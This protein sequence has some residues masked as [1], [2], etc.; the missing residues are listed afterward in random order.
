VIDCALVVPAY[1]E[2][3]EI[4]SVVADLAAI[5]PV[6]VV[7][8]ASP[9]DTAER[10]R[11]AG[12]VV[13]SLT[14]NRGYGA[15]ID[16]GFREAVDRG[17]GHVV[18]VDG[19]GQHDPADVR[20]MVEQVTAGAYDL[21]VGIR[22][23][24]TRPVERLCAL[25]ARAAFGVRDPLC[26]LKAYDTRFFAEY[27]GFNRLESVGTELMT[28]ALRHGARWTQWPIAIRTRPNGDS[29]FYRNMRGNLRILRSLR[30]LVL[31]R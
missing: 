31:V 21:V 10:A 24:V 19:D 27:G 23:E 20:R 8:D 14:E 2:A 29:R 12:A 9:D 22:P 4:A 6:I 16:A 18:T 11:A 3:G 1:R 7:D 30:A 5:A 17:F 15:A 13:I 25:Y 28:Y 26:G